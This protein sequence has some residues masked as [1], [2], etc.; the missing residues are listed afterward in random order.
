MYFVTTLKCKLNKKLRENF[1]SENCEEIAITKE[2]YL[3]P[4]K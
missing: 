4:S 3:C 1:I 2:K